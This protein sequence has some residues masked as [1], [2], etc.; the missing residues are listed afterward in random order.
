VWHE[1]S[2]DKLA[3]TLK[4]QDYVG[5]FTVGRLKPKTLSEAMDN[6]LGLCV[7]G[8]DLSPSRTRMP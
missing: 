7:T 3:A 5:T 6:R 4:E 2:V 1:V 8:Y